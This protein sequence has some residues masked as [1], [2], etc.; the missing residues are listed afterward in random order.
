MVSSQHSQGQQAEAES[1][2]LRLG[3]CPVPSE[4]CLDFVHCE[5]LSTT[6]LP[7]FG[8]ILIMLPGEKLVHSGAS[9][10]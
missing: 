6:P 1:S 5:L 3:L 10:I 8:Q 2:H 7:I 9:L 4:Q